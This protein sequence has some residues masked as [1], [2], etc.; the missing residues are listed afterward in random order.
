MEG[1]DGCLCIIHGHLKML[2]R[3]DH[4]LMPRLLMESSGRG[5]ANRFSAGDARVLVKFFGG[6]FCAHSMDNAMYE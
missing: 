1:K 6:N 4:S 2:H 3:H 5:L